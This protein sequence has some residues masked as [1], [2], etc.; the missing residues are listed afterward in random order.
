MKKKII[1][2]VL[3]CLIIPCTFMFSGCQTIKNIFRK[4][5]E[6]EYT[7][8]F[9]NESGEVIYKGNYTAGSE[10][11]S[12]PTIDCQK[13]YELAGW[14]DKSTNKLVDF[15]NM[16]ANNL[17]V[18][19]RFGKR[20]YITYENVFD[21]DKTKLKN[22]SDYYCY[23]NGGKKE[24]PTEFDFEE[25]WK[26]V[27]KFE[28]WY[29]NANFDG[30]RIYYVDE[31]ITGDITFYAK[32]SYTNYTITYSYNSDEVGDVISSKYKTFNSDNMFKLPIVEVPGYEFSGWTTED[33]KKITYSDENGFCNKT[34]YGNYRKKQYTIYYKSNV[35]ITKKDYTIFKEGYTILDDRCLYEEGKVYSY[36]DKLLTWEDV[37]KHLEG[38]KFRYWECTDNRI[39]YTDITTCLD[40]KSDE[41]PILIYAYWD[42]VE[43]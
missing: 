29:D 40:F 32:W 24:L 34:V 5:E 33:N 10:Y 16:P 36:G 20:Y 15:K 25:E 3:L 18:Y 42:D 28:G 12:I 6:K 7:I 30:E 2:L 21:Y 4:S 37:F 14:L 1:S 27:Q 26:D 22:D 17:T 8:K 23:I 39:H 38:Y 43:E 41:E 13:G 9:E 31:D 11:D 19:P 35:Y